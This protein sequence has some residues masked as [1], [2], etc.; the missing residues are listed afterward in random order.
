VRKNGLGA[1]A[2][3]GISKRLKKAIGFAPQAV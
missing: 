1:A 3:A 2:Q